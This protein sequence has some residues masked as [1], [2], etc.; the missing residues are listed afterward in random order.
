MEHTAFQNEKAKISSRIKALLSKTVESGATE[1]EAFSAMTKAHELLEKYQ[2]TLDGVELA[3]DGFQKAAMPHKTNKYDIIGRNLCLYISRYTET[4]TWINT[5][6]NEKPEVVFFGLRSD[7]EFA[8]WIYINLCNFI[9]RE[10]LNHLATRRSAGDNVGN[11]LLCQ[12]SFITGATH[13]IN[14]RLS[15]E[16]EARKPKQ[17]SNGT[18][19]MVVKNQLVEAELGKLGL[20]LRKGKATTRRL[21]G[22]V[23]A[24]K[25]AGDRANWKRPVGGSAGGQLR[26]GGF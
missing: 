26:I 23:E 25:A 3:S 14:Q 18:S 13:R 19:L 10:S 8:Q 6:D 9:Q 4:R 17:A 15:E 1:E 11:G 21:D 12:I 5:R 24:G 20:N 22:N 2:M 16:I 7:V